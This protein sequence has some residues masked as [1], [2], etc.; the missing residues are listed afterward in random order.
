MNGQLDNWEKVDD[1]GEGGQSNVILVRG[2]KRI[3]GRKG[4]IQRILD[5]N[6]WGTVMD[7]TRELRTGQF[8]DAVVE[9]ARPESPTE[10]GALKIFKLRETSPQEKQEALG[11]L[12]QEIAVLVQNREG[13]SRL[14]DA[15]EE[16]G[17]IVTEYFPELALENHP[18]K[19][20]GKVAPAL[21]AFRS[22][23]ETVASLHRD[24]YIHRDIKPANVFIR[25][26][27]KLVL[28]D[29]GIVYAPSAPDRMTKSLERVG[30]RDYI[31]LWA[32]LGERLENVR[33]SIDVYMLG[34]LLWSMVDG[35]AVLPRECYSDP[36]LDFDLTEKFP[37]DPHMYAINRIL[38]KSVVAQER[39]CLP[40]A[41]DLLLMVEEFLS[42]IERG[43]QLL[44]DDIPRPCHVCGKGFYKPE[45]LRQD[46]TT[47]V[48]RIWFTGAQDHG[49]EKLGVRPFVCDNA[50]C[51]H[52]QFFHPK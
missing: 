41:D 33:P 25:N 15:N 30:P 43:G 17:W 1:L 38:D 47:G 28:G 26:N 50:Y 35:R 3:K 10:L 4:G 27:D 49:I 14:L 37:N 13:L 44:Q 23:V 6:P 31:P 18:S 34:K 16:E 24:G 21:R 12:R 5:S 52:I 29:F 46:T 19:Y 42:I 11:R 45:P 8:A 32:N 20:R 2:L 7:N 51:G 9:Y 36:E 39:N 48:L 22:L 40:S